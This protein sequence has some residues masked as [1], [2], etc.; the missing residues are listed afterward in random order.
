[1]KYRHPSEFEVI[2][3]KL[4]QDMPDAAGRLSPSGLLKFVNTL[5]LLDT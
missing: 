3:V 2:V 4:L 5:G 1:M